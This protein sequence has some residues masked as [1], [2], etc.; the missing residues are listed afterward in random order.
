MK[1]RA[2]A[3]IMTTLLLVSIMM[4]VLPAHAQFDGEVKIGI[5]GPVGLPHWSPAGMKEAAIMAATE[6]ND[7]DGIELIDGKK[8]EVVLVFADEHALPVPDPDAAKAEIVKLCA[9]DNVHFIIGGFRTEVTSAMIE[10]AMDYETPFLINGASTTEL[11]SDTVGVNYARY[12]Y[13]FRNMPMNS[14]DLVL[15]IMFYIN[16]LCSTK[17]LPIYGQPIGPG[18]S[19]QVPIGVLTED[20]AWTVAMH[21]LLTDPAKYVP[22][23]GPNVNVTYADRIPETATDTSSW[24]N[25]V[26][27]GVGGLPPP[28]IMIHV[29]SGRA[30]L[31][32]I[33]QW[34]ELGVAALPIGINVLAQIEDHWDN[35]LGKCEYETVLNPSGT[36][37]AIIPG[38]TDV[39]FDAFVDAYDKWPIYTAYGAYDTIMGMA[40]A[41]NPGS[42]VNGGWDAVGY[43]NGSLTAAAIVDNL[44]STDR[45]SMMGRFQYTSIHDVKSTSLG[46]TWD[47]AFTRASMIQWYGTETMEVVCPVDQLYTVKHKLIPWS[48]PAGKESLAETDTVSAPGTI[49]GVNSTINGIVNLADIAWVTG[50]WLTEPGDL[51]YNYNAD[52]DGNQYINIIDVAT[53]AKDYLDS[54]PTPL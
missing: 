8:Y 14:L 51:L 53:I 28:R 47:R 15:S 5:V 2:F 32:L 49:P 7:A 9:V 3:G 45:M 17:L 52:L 54:Y 38:V 23:L 29:F 41:A 25:K 22:L 44:E 43:L 1:S 19:L 6:I 40:D 27:N 10:V 39:F 37:T 4:Y 42:L 35:T 46:P 48:F 18:G 26:K 21:V 33:T 24:L 50:S 16:Y 34:K 36:G 11:I 30:G 31:P 13:L 20:L 12:K